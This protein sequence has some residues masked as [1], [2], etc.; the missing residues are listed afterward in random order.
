MQNTKSI[1]R[2]DEQ[3]SQGCP[4]PVAR[5]KFS[6]HF[7]A[8]SHRCLKIELA[9]SSLGGVF[10]P[11]AMNHERRPAA[12]DVNFRKRLKRHEYS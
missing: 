8:T 2:F 6:S 11:L 10:Y 7:L 4:R 9:E 1:H 3:S 5:K 12:V